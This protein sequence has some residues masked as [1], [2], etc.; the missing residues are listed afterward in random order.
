MV[1]YWDALLEFICEHV[2][3]IQ[4]EELY[5]RGSGFNAS[6][7]LDGRFD[8]AVPATGTELDEYV[9]DRYGAEMDMTRVGTWNRGRAVGSFWTDSQ[10]FATRGLNT[11]APLLR[12]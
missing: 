2:P 7:E 5:V 10:E 4:D 8:V 1:V 3:T 11:V 9:L 12:V 6:G